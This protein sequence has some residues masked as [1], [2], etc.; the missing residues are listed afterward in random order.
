MRYEDKLWVCKQGELSADEDGYP[1]EPQITVAEFG[2]CF[3]SFNK[4]AAHVQL[5]DGQDYQYSF[6]IIAPLKKALYPLIPVEG[7]QVI[8]KKADETVYCRLKVSG[9]VT[10][11]KRFLKVWASQREYLTEQEVTSLLQD[12]ESGNQD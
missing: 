10:Y 12:A 3:L 5:A 7:E 11:K 9:F 4:A 6:Y 2:K 8:V 1:V